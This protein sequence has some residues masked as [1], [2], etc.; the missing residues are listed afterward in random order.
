MEKL[1]FE[2]RL[3]RLRERIV[4][5]DFLANRGLGNEV[6]FYIF[7]YAPERELKLR[8]YLDD[9]KSRDL[10]CR[11]HERNLWQTLLGCCE[12]KGI[13]GKIAAL[14]LKRGSDALLDRLQT[15]ATPETLAAAMDWEPHRPGDVLF[16]TG[17][18]EACPFVRAHQ[19][20]DAAQPVFSASSVK[21]GVPLVLF[22]PGTYDG[23][24]LSLFGRLAPNN[25]YR[26]F[27][28]I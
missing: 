5:P 3:D 26:A 1:T 4:Q 19:V 20:L 9:L 15:I 2:Q 10:P 23:Q 14:E 12:A 16:I 28:L 17:V 27:D 11:I 22:Y 13:L 7:Q 18:G 8:A 24:S 6:G 21:S 25:Y